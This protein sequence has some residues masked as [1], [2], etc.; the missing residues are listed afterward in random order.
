MLDQFRALLDEHLAKAKLKAAVSGSARAFSQ[1]TMFIGFGFVF[2]FGN[3]LII[4][5]E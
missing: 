3:G 5:D 4:N 2:W 1:G